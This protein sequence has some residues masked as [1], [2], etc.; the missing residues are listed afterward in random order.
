MNIFQLKV[1]NRIRKVADMLHLSNAVYVVSLWFVRSHWNRFAA[2]NEMNEKEAISALENYSPDPKT[3]CIGKNVIRCEDNPLDLQIVIP[4][5]N[6][7]KH[8]SS[9]ID[10]IL[11]QKTE[12]SYKVVI[13]DD[14]ST[15]STGQIAD[16]YLS[17]DRVVVIHQPNGGSSA[18]RNR[19]L[20]VISANYLMFVDSDDILLPDAL[21]FL[22]RVAYGRD[23]DIVEG[24]H[25]A[26]TGNR[27]IGTFRYDKDT[28]VAYSELQ[29]FVWGKVYRNTLFLNR[30]FPVGYWHQDT[31][32][33]FII[34]PAA[35]K[36]WV[37]RN[38]VYE[39]RLSSMSITNSAKQRPKAIDT[40]WITRKLH[41]E[42]MALNYNDGEIY[43]STLRKQ[44]ARNTNRIL[45]LP[46]SVQ[47]AVFV[48]SAY[49]F[50][51][52]C[53]RSDIV[54]R[55]KLNIMLY[56]ILLNRRY[57]D[58]RQAVLWLL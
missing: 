20:E 1:H 21:Q 29:G 54:L 58:F 53:D 4:A 46:E 31:I 2:R 12:Y 56:D 45:C 48:A 30:V 14:G 11:S 9:C 23:A 19:G 17:D 15:D 42:R 51:G 24:G 34:H 25:N 6:V 35:S 8:L 49:L 44:I 36:I 28:E 10:S 40:F 16:T 47:Y 38:V 18:A 57:A 5:Y 26:F 37:V 52:A 43:I 33:S 41:E 22:L 13:V 39:H 55:D 32:A 3:S 27:F 7:G 50:V